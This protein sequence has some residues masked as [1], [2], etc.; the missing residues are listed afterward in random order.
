MPRKAYDTPEDAIRASLAAGRVPCLR[1]SV[2]RQKKL[3]VEALALA[4]GCRVEKVG[5]I[6][7]FTKG[8]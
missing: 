2:V 8:D 4:V 7:R 6:Y 1:E 3:D 5:A